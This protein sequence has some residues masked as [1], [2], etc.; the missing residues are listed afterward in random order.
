MRGQ[1]QPVYRQQFLSMPGRHRTGR[2]HHRQRTADPDVAL[3]SILRLSV[4]RRGGILWNAASTPKCFPKQVSARKSALGSNPVC[5][6]INGAKCSAD[7]LQLL[8]RMEFF[9]PGEMREN[10]PSRERWGQSERGA[11]AIRPATVTE[12]GPLLAPAGIVAAQLDL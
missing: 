3:A 8:D 2:A 5:C 6:A 1:Q 4:K 10:P 12:A 7:F 11:A 9:V